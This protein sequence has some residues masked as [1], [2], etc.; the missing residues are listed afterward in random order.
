MI[1]CPTGFEKIGGGTALESEFINILMIILDRG[2]DDARTHN[3]E[4]R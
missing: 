1:R 3:F 4:P 2:I